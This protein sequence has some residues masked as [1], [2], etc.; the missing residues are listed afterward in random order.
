[1]LRIEAKNLGKEYN[2]LWIF[3]HLTFSINTP[4]VY[5][6]KG[7]NGSGKSTLLR[8]LSGF[9]SPSEGKCS[10]IKNGNEIPYEHIYKNF[11][12]AA[13]YIELPEEL[14]LDELV[15]FQSKF[16]PF[17]LDTE[18]IIRNSGLAT[19]SKRLLN[20]YSS[21]MKQRVKLLLAIM[22]NT[23]VLILDEPI[24][25]L[26]DTA[27]DWFRNLLNQHKDNRI[28]IIASNDDRDFEGAEMLVNFHKR[29]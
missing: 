14:S 22:S 6:I 25:N 10:W 2:Y 24:T 17:S 4:G 1:M 20:T 5:G 8:L 28:T 21:G 16:K 3:R 27:I 29:D 11:A 23:P 13:P 9:V 26:D 12:V 7:P 18:E 19:A 15:K